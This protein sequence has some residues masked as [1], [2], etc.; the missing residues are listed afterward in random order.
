M[1]NKTQKLQ[2]Q[3]LMEKLKDKLKFI[4]KYNYNIDEVVGVKGNERYILYTQKKLIRI[5][6][7]SL[8]SSPLLCSYI[9]IDKAIFYNFKIEKSVL[10]KVDLKS[11]IETKVYEEAGV[12]ETQEYEIKY[13]IVDK[14]KDDKYVV[15][16]TVIIATEDLDREFE[17]ILKEA[18]YIDYLSFPAFS[19]R[20]LYE[21]GILKKGNDLFVV[22][23]YDKIFL[24]FYSEGE[25]VY[26]N[27]LAEG[28]ERV[29]DSLSELKIRGFNLELF[30]KLLLKK[31][32]SIGKYSSQE[33]VILEIIK[34]H[35]SN[36]GDLILEEINKFK[37]LYNIDSLDRIFITSEYGD[38]QEADEYLQHLLNLEV[39]SFEFYEKYN[40]D[41]LPVDP[42][43]FL[44]MLETHYA[45]KYE[46]QV[47]NFSRYLRKPT[48][49]YRP[50][51]IL[52][53]SVIGSIIILGAYPLYLYLNGLSYENKNKELQKKINKLL[54]KKNQ[55]Q[56]QLKKLQAV[57]NKLSN[58][59]KENQ[60]EIKRI[61]KFIE[62]VYKFKF[63]YMPKSQELVEIT[64]LM[65]KNKVY[66][67]IIEYNNHS[68]IIKVFSYHESD[69]PNLIKDLADNGFSVDFDEILFKNGKYN[70][71]IRIQE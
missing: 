70:S 23:L 37:E 61:Q 29:Y 19:Y 34:K 24:T 53:L 36:I 40:L 6:R 39:K 1:K 28:L 59:I 56:T 33:L 67:D 17:Y 9:P 55:L 5:Y 2:I 4:K 44:A 51:G 62:D 45:Y 22:L 8:K 54:M 71:Q 31:G 50:V 20:A 15:I 42:F 16:E 49:F 13:K 32:L 18:G 52:A 64:Y 12:E 69:I 41:R 14:L 27:T 11:Y 7:G 35:F 60:Q 68:Y 65:N 30:K 66:A 10:E 63:S 46:N 58:I 43:L 47:Y 3:E 57:D 26:M 38:I 21:E 48:F 25:L